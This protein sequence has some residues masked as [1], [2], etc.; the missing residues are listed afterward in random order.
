A[1]CVNVPTASTLELHA[2]A[3]S[4]VRDM[5]ILFDDS[6]SST[7]PRGRSTTGLWL[8]VGLHVIA[9][10]VLVV[11]PIRAF[12]KPPTPRAPS[13]MVF[14]V[15]ATALLKLPAPPVVA[16][17]LPAPPTPPQPIRELA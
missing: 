12:E 9:A 7:R 4:S 1:C 8:S 3:L 11:D 2:S 16:P 10:V 14:I 13:R 5:S 17:R 15:P 6:R